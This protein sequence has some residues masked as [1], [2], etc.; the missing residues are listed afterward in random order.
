MSCQTRRRRLKNE[1]DVQ[2]T[3]RVHRRHGNTSIKG[4]PTDSTTSSQ[5]STNQY[6]DALVDKDALAVEWWRNHQQ[7]GDINSSNGFSEKRH[8]IDSMPKGNMD[9]KTDNETLVNAP[10]F[11]IMS[12]FTTTLENSQRDSKGRPYNIAHQDP[13]AKPT[14][15]MVLDPNSIPKETVNEKQSGE[16]PSLGIFQTKGRPEAKNGRDQIQFFQPRLEPVSRAKQYRW[17]LP[18]QNENSTVVPPTNEII[19]TV[20]NCYG[21]EGNETGTSP[22]S[23]SAVENKQIHSQYNY[24]GDGNEIGNRSISTT[25]IKNTQIQKKASLYRDAALL[26]EENE[27][28]V[29]LSEFNSWM[30]EASP[31]RTRKVSDKNPHTATRSPKRS[32]EH[33]GN[34]CHAIQSGA[35]FGTK[36][37]DEVPEDT[38]ISSQSVEDRV[39][40]YDGWSLQDPTGYPFSILGTEGCERSPRVFTPSMMETLRGFMPMKLANHNFWLRFSL[41]RDGSSFGKLLSSVRASTFTVIGVETNYGEVFG[42]FTASPWRMGSTWYGSKEA[43]LWRLKDKRYTSPKNARKSNFERQMELYHCTDN[44]NFIQYCT[45]ETIAVGGGEWQYN[46]CPYKDSNQGIGLVI[47]GD[48]AGGETNSCATFAN[49]KLARHATVSSEF[50]ISNLEVWSLTPFGHIERAFEKELREFPAKGVEVLLE[51]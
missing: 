15:G 21:D 4:N 51:R 29:S 17:H 48:L 36:N 11:N 1:I 35:F 40:R 6:R 49:P 47:D 34:S 26:D 46:S 37:H 7:L 23:S 8:Q 41:A 14:D 2:S 10:P 12:P 39:V 38:E 5:S 32:I 44:D 42:C 25:A 33:I 27:K 13:L 24:Y 22:I 16:N 28:E 50:S 31:E 9:E 19:S 45:A 20:F 3:A 30:S 43:F 18:S